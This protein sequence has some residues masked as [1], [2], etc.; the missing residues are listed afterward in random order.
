MGFSP[1]KTFGNKNVGAGI[2]LLRIETAS[3]DA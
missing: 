1:L 3:S 2:P